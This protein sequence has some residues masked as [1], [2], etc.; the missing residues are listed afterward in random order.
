MSR[1]MVSRVALST[2]TVLKGSVEKH[3]QSL[4]GCGTRCE[5]FVESVCDQD[6]VS[7]TNNKSQKKSAVP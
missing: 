1:R 5:M 7:D 3:I 2:I 6:E 4:E